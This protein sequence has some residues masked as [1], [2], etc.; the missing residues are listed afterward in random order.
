M[1][2]E[3]DVEL[4]NSSKLVAAR[5]Q[6]SRQDQVPHPQHRSLCA[7]PMVQAIVNLQQQLAA[8]KQVFGWGVR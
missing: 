2:A 1:D 4:S 7:R 3:G 8:C 5:L 6:A